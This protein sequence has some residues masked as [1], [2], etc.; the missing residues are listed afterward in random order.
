MCLPAVATA[1]RNSW[2]QQ[3]YIKASNTETFDHF[4]YAIALSGDGNTLAVSA[5]DE[6]SSVTGIGGNQTDNSAESSGAVYVFTRSGSGWS[7]QAYIK[8]NN[9]EAFNVFGWA[10]A[11][12]GDGITLAVGAWGEESNAIGIGGDQTD[13][14]EF[15]AGA[16]YLY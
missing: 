12:S 7:Q 2:S 11:L 14:S 4:G 5:V 13:N 1:G 6:D 3:A 15:D 8:A 9:T 16:L 10:V